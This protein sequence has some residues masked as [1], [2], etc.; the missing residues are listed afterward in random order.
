MS[1][2]GCW[3]FLESQVWTKAAADKWASGDWKT[4]KSRMKVQGE[5]SGELQRWSLLWGG[6]GRLE[7]KG[8]PKF[9]LSKLQM[10]HQGIW[11]ASL[12]QNS[13]PSGVQSCLRSVSWDPSVSK[14]RR[15]MSQPDSGHLSMPPLKLQLYIFKMHIIKRD[16]E[17]H[18]IKG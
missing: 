3:F 12:C 5:K 13:H 1:I 14:V 6:L 10:K 18:P 15:L 17:V 8:K 4:G 7:G 2:T 11:P 9:N 16:P